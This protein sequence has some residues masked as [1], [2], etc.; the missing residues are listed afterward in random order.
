MTEGI[1]HARQR[2]AS[3]DD[4]LHRTALHKL[5]EAEVILLCW[6]N[7]EEAHLVA[8]EHGNDGSQY[9]GLKQPLRGAPDQEIGPTWG[10]RTL[11]FEERTVRDQIKDQVVALPILGEVFLRV[12]NHIVRAV[13]AHEVLLLRVVDSSDLSPE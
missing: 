3:I 10:Q 8:P 4:W 13:R 6:A 7:D 12:V 5:Q 2:E 11:E 1:G 9:Q